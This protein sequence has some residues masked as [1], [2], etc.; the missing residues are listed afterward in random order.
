MS[1]SPSSREANESGK[2]ARSL[3]P[4]QWLCS[5][6]QLHKIKNEIFSFDCLAHV[7]FLGE[8]FIR[9]NPTTSLASS[10]FLRV[11]AEKKK[12]K[13]HSQG[14]REAAERTK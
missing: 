14:I 7:F 2:A 8:I 4:A 11:E 6:I 9:A 12:L 10:K 3:S 5:K 13:E 1:R